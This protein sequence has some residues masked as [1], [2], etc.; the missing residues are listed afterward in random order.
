[1]KS[2]KS[3]NS[4]LSAE[5]IRKVLTILENEYG[6]TGT[7][8]KF[9]SKF[10]LLV[11][12]MMA[13]QST[14]KQVNKITQSLFTELPDAAAFAR[15]S[16]EELEEKIKQVG[17]FRSKARNIVAASKMILNEFDGNVP[18]SRDELMKLPGVG[19]KTANVVLSVG[20]RQDAIAVDTHVF[21]VSNRIGLASGKDVRQTEEHLMRNIPRKKWS[22][23]HH[24]LIWHGRKICKAQKPAC[25][26][27]P[28]REYCRHV[29]KQ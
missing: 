9:R 19:R 3:K 14:D 21:R 1:M 13:A 23:A 27:C 20:F 18:D 17:L 6:N 7:A 10:Q 5:K 24:W 12:T 8:L 29:Q 15:I 11:S 26:I 4:M 2:Q 25:E 16:P 22:A 28:I